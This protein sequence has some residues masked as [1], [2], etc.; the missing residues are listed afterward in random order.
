[1][2]CVFVYLPVVVDEMKTRHAGE[3]ETE[4]KTSITKR[5]KG[6]CPFSVQR[7]DIHSYLSNS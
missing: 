7:N 4:T 1:M 3:A 6:M 5:N 2:Y